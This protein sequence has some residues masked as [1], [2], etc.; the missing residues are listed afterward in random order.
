MWYLEASI[1]PLLSWLSNIKKCIQQLLVLLF[2]R[3]KAFK[4]KLFVDYL[5]IAGGIKCVK[6]IHKY[7]KRCNKKKLFELGSFF[8]WPQAINWLDC[9]NYVQLK[10]KFEMFRKQYTKKNQWNKKT[11]R[12]KTCALKI[13]ANFW[14]KQQDRRK[15]T[16][17]KKWK[18][19]ALKTLCNSTLA[20]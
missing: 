10:A 1:T 7:F 9:H 8:Y 3:F 12:K 4:E 20:M 2:C 17:E 13:S 6:Q 14:Q 15:S 5:Q 19:Q 11:C 16:V 18:S